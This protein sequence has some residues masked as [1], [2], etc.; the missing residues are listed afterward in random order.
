MVFNTTFNHISVISW[1]KQAPHSMSHSLKILTH[2]NITFYFKHLCLLGIF[3]IKN[4]YKL[5]L[6]ILFDSK[7]VKMLMFQ[8]LLQ[9]TP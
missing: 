9:N 2:I 1:R 6:H 8:I 4:K 3:Y 7:E 5:K